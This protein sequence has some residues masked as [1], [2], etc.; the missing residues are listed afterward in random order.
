MLCYI[1]LLFKSKLLNLDFGL[2]FLGKLWSFKT[3]LPKFSVSCDKNR[4]W[5]ANKGPFIQCCICK[6]GSRNTRELQ[7]RAIFSGLFTNLAAIICG[8]LEEEN[9]HFLLCCSNLRHNHYLSERSGFGFFGLISA[10]TRLKLSGRFRFIFLCSYFLGTLFCQILIVILINDHPSQSPQYSC[11]CM[12]H[13]R[14][15]MR[16]TSSSPID[17]THILKHLRLNRLTTNTCP[18]AS[19]FDGFLSLMVERKLGWL[20]GTS[21]D[22]SSIHQMWQFNFISDIF[23]ECNITSNEFP[24]FSPSPQHRGIYP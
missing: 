12:C 11:L 14:T 22:F 5:F 13:I 21:S 1:V 23:G 17:P 16:L 20:V 15:P 7:W 19:Y 4:P 8:H 24:L 2:H 3:V 6:K 9:P 18:E 10:K